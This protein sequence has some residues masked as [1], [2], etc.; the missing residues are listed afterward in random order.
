MPSALQLVLLLLAA[1]VLVVTL[2]RFL[3]LPPVLGYLLVG[4]VLGPHATGVVP[5]PALTERL[6]EFGVVFLM[7]SIGLEFS[8]PN[9]FGMRRIV[10]GL[11]LGQVAVTLVV[12]MLA[13][14]VFG[15]GWAGSFALGAALAMSS[16][17]VLSRLLAERVELDSRHGRE[18][19]GVLLFQDIAVVPLL[20]LIP[21]LS[22]PTEKM[23]PI[24][25]VALLKAVI[26]LGLVIFLG[27]RFMRGWFFIVAARKSAELFVL[28]VLLITLGLAWL[29]EMAG[30]SMALGAFLAGMLVAE[31]EFRYQVEEDIKPFRDVLLGLFF[32]TVGMF[33]DLRLVVDNLL[34]VLVVL[35]LLLVGKLGVVWGLSRLFG[36]HAGTALRSGLWLCAG[37]EFGFVIL[38]RARDLA[39][40]TPDIQQVA[41][42]VLV[43]S[44]LLAPLL[45][46]FSDRI[47]MRLVAS[48]WLLRSMQLTQIAARTMGTE[49][50]AILCG[51]GRTG[52]HLA[53]FL[54]QEQIS[55]IALDLDP[56]R[57][58]DAAAAGESVVYGDCTRRETLTAAGIARA[59]VLV[60]TFADRPAALKVLHHA[61]SLRPELSI[62]VRTGEESDIDLLVAAG[63]TEVIPEALESSAM[64]ATHA[65]AL[66]G[67]PM[68]RVVRRLREMREAHYTLLRGFFHGSSDA[69]DSLADAEQ[70][71]L[72]SVVLGP[73]AAVIGRTAGET[74]QELEPL[75]CT[76]SVVRRRA[77]GARLGAGQTLQEGDVLVLLGTPAALV[78]AEAAMLTGRSRPS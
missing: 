42:S 28:N 50:H 64:L 40:I 51:Y 72:H 54:E 48:E 17:A 37:G 22:G 76:L 33:L 67:I 47:V 25:G 19:I 9:L 71:R 7:F 3:N 73:D 63:A 21:A 66:L 2:F 53:R 30:L 43:L 27:Q 65:L 60:V 38:T 5:D 20:I 10:F 75:G 16:T 13:A 32:I 56:E 74:E 68:S 31:T 11:G 36:A 4:A 39:V 49:K 62:L 6:A 1:A 23:L 61:R 34:W 57:V 29:T 46:Q 35:G 52:Q 41:L 58:R 78:A 24:L 77:S 55:C 69:H 8:L 44:L 15:V 26:A 18:V 59:H 12:A 14:R 70:P 45:V